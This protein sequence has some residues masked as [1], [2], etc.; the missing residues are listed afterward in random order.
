MFIF[1]IGVAKGT[2]KL[3]IPSSVPESFQLLMKTCWEQCP[4]DRPSFKQIIKRLDIS[5]PEIVLFEQE[6]EYAEITRIWSGEVHEN[7]SKLPTVDIFSALAM[8]Y[9]EL[10]KQR[11]EEIQLISN[12]RAHYQKRVQ[13]INTL[14]TELKSLMIQ[15]EERERV[16][17]ERECFRRID[18][19]TGNTNPIFKARKNSSKLKRVAATNVD[20]FMTSISHR[21]RREYKRNDERKLF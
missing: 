16:I 13:Q 2:L 20:H 1:N 21:K 7:L 14:Y 18:E 6:Q 5:K 19:K 9:D 11:K 15:L 17:N 3:P 12:M 8:N 10:M 4:S